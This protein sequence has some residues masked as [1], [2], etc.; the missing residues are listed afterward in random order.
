M[1]SHQ[2]SLDRSKADNDRSSALPMPGKQTLVRSD[3]GLSGPSQPGTP[4]PANDEAPEAAA[5]NAAPGAQ[6]FE[7]DGITWIQRNDGA[8][9]CIKA[10]YA[11]QDMRHTVIDRAL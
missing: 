5:G 10:P 7:D 2:G 1:L 6:P 9:E 11:R 3:P 8:F 4:T